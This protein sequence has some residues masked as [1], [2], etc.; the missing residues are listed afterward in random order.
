M[1][2]LEQ[3]LQ[4]YFNVKKPFLKTPKKVNGETEYFTRRGGKAFDNLNALLWDLT[5][6]GVISQK[7][8]ETAVNELD[9]ISKIEG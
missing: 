2:T 7:A 8:V 6:I 5:T 9:H 3:I 1:V 4:Q